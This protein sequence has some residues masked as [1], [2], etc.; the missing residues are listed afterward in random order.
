[1]KK[2]VKHRIQSGKWIEFAI[3][4]WDERGL[5]AILYTKTSREE[6]NEFKKEITEKY[7]EIHFVSNDI[8][9]VSPHV[10]Q[11]LFKKNPNYKKA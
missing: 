8:S 2:L 10:I 5:D 7:P 1:M 9:V 6:F 3:E 11:S 4:K